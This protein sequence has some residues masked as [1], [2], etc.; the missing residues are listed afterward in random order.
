MGGVKEMSQRT[1]LALLSWATAMPLRDC[2][3][4]RRCRGKVTDWRVPLLRDYLAAGVISQVGTGLS[5]EVGVRRQVFHRWRWDSV[6][7]WGDRA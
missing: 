5:R 1:Q 7:S 2:E 6:T 4:P 3:G